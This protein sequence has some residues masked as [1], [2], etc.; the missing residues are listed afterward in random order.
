MG[1]KTDID[2]SKYRRGFALIG[3]LLALL[4]SAASSRAQYHL[5]LPM[6]YDRYLPW[7]ARALGMGGTA[8]ASGGAL[9]LFGLPD[10]TSQVRRWEAAAS[11]AALSAGRSHVSIESGE[12]RAYPVAAAAAVRLGAHRLSAGYRRAMEDHLTFPNVYD[13]RLSD[14]ADLELDQAQVAWSYSTSGN[15]SLGLG[16]CYNRAEFNWG[17][18]TQLDGIVTGGR[19][20]GYSFSAG[21]SIPLTPE[22]KI[23]FAASTKSEIKGTA[24][25]IPDTSSANDL[26]LSGAVPSRTSAAVSYRPETGFTVVAEATMT[27]WN[28]VTQS[29]EGKLDFGL[30]AEIWLTNCLAA[31]L[32]AFSKMSPL[33]DLEMRLEPSLQD[34]YFVTA[35]IGLTWKGLRLDLGGAS[36]RA[37]SGPGQNQGILAATFSYGRLVHRGSGG[38]G[39]AAD[40]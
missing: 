5:R 14:N 29:Y 8:A 33:D 13:P 2:A 34:L 36:S 10:R 23:S 7:S 24:E 15:A 40:G 28:A 1:M 26:E 17:N 16:L 11:V 21:I 38:T 31:R 12:T 3:A 37:L 22:V 19:A 35:G 18:P 9:S 27:G 20:T 30:G 4:L 32:G 39:T 6:Q 25:Y